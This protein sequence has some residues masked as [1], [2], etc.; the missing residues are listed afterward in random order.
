MKN[1]VLVLIATIVAQFTFAQNTTEKVI[2]FDDYAMKFV[3]VTNFDFEVVKTESDDAGMI[4]YQEIEGLNYDGK[5]YQSK[6]KYLYQ[7][8]DYFL[9][10]LVY[11]KTIFPIKDELEEDSELIFQTLV[12]R[13]KNEN[14]SSLLDIQFEV[15][16]K[17]TI[18][19]NPKSVLGIPLPEVYESFNKFSKIH[20][21]PFGSGDDFRQNGALD[22]FKR[23]F[24][25][26]P[27]EYGSRIE[28]RISTIHLS[29]G[30]TGYITSYVEKGI[31]YTQKEETKILVDN[32]NG[33]PVRQKDYL[34]VK[35]QVIGYEVEYKINEFG[36]ITFKGIIDSVKFTGSV[37]IEDS[38]FEGE[39]SNYEILP[40][41]NTINFGEGGIIV[42]NCRG[43]GLGG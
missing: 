12:L 3:Q 17:S 23:N 36:E 39:Y 28:P 35:D 42:V 11:T 21:F 16:E 5:K 18:V 15:I 19:N 10:R 13:P 4:V 38:L 33:F 14:Y 43:Y 30:K 9:E 7:K 25:W 22:F 32:F 31:I 2:C 41:T 29:K 27:K 37:E 6:T 1:L 20:S 24:D 26:D 34:V 8:E 40:S